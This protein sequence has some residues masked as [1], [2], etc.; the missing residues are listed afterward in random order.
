M[1]L[2]FYSA[3]KHI[4]WYFSFSIWLTSLSMIIYRSTMYLQKTW[5]YSF[6][7]WIIFYSVY[8]IISISV[9]PQFLYPFICV[10]TLGCFHVLAIINRAVVTLEYMYLQTMVFTK[11]IPRIWRRKW[12]PTPVFLPRESCGQRSMGRLQSMALQLSDWA[13]A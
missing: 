12:Q 8:E 7:G 11:Y 4:S 5:F 6:C 9:L 3:Q 10:W 1:Y 2:F 13:H